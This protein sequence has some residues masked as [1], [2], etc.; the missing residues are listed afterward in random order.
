MRTQSQKTDLKTDREKRHTNTITM[1]VVPNVAAV[2][3]HS[4]VA[5]AAYYAAERRGFEPGFELQDWLTAEHE[6]ETISSGRD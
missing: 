1:T 4:M 5:E 2:D 6:I 3:R